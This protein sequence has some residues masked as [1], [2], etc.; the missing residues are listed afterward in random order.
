[1]NLGTPLLSK[2]SVQKGSKGKAKAGSGSKGHEV[3]KGQTWNKGKGK[4]GKPGKGFGKKGK[5]NE[6]SETDYDTWWWYE[7]D[8]NG[9]TYDGSVEQ[10]SS[11]YDDACQWEDWNQNW[12]HAGKDATVT[13]NESSDTKTVSEVAKH[14]GK[15]VGSLILSPVCLE[16]QKRT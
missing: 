12:E 16:Q 1:M 15:P 11:T 7:S 3:Q 13:W 6:M 9:Y 2:E 14:E 5:L 8:W 4:K 10:V